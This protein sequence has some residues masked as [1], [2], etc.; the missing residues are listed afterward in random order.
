MPLLLPRA[1]QVCISSHIC[2][3]LA[4]WSAYP[5]SNQCQVMSSCCLCHGTVIKRPP[6]AISSL[7]ISRPWHCRTVGPSIN[8]MMTGWWLEW[9][10]MTGSQWLNLM[11]IGQ[12]SMNPNSFKLVKRFSEK[13]WKVAGLR[14]NGLTSIQHQI[15]RW[16]QQWRLQSSHGA[17]TV[18][19]HN[20]WGPQYSDVKGNFET[21]GRWLWKPLGDKQ[22]TVRLVVCL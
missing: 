15:E 3:H 4:I 6:G 21:I 5:T 7:H 2:I 19:G 12:L 1:H 17:A 8:W 11:E 20:P 9:L 13:L 14:I 10:G 18:L 22:N 16:C